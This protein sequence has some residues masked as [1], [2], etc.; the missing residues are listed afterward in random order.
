M[1]VFL[2]CVKNT[3]RWRTIDGQIRDKENTKQKQKQTPIIEWMVG[4]VCVQFFHFHWAFGR[5]KVL[6][7]WVL[8]QDTWLY[9]PFQSEQRNKLPGYL[10]QCTM[11]HEY[12]SFV[13]RILHNL[14]GYTGFRE[15][16]SD[17][18]I[19]NSLLRLV[20]NWCWLSHS[21]IIF[22]SSNVKML[23]MILRGLQNG[24]NFLQLAMSHQADNFQSAKANRLTLRVSLG[25]HDGVTLHS[26]SLQR[27]LSRKTSECPAD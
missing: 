1:C 23:M 7:D 15:T 3:M 24:R 22:K 26:F 19:P 13:K 25:F 27:G 6:S 9:C 10:W 5:H 12:L 16:I 18:S 4:S 17:L 8:R 2:K 21:S 14:D 20:T 11:K